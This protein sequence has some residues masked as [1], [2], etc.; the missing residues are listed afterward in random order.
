[1]SANCAHGVGDGRPLAVLGAEPDV[2][3]RAP[4][5]GLAAWSGRT[6]SVGAVER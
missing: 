5:R 1:M 6:V 3:A 2:G 4:D